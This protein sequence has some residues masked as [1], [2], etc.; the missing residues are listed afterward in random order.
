M[1]EVGSLGLASSSTCARTRKC[2]AEHC[3]CGDE[4]SPNSRFPLR[5]FS[6]LV[7]SSIGSSYILMAAVQCASPCHSTTIWLFFHT[8][9]SLLQL[10]LVSA[11]TTHH[12]SPSRRAKT[13]AVGCNP[14]WRS[15][16]GQSDAD[17]RQISSRPQSSAADC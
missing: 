15:L 10:P 9:P 17:V 1:Q 8:P 13:S 2:I 16:Y 3:L 6:F 5:G 14:Q 7:L 11:A 12:P 4:R